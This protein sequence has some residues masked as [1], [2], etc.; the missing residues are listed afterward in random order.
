MTS[1]FS[2]YAS[3]VRMN[4]Q[5]DEPDLYEVD[6]NDI[7]DLLS[8][9]K[10]HCRNVITIERNSFFLVLD[11][12][13]ASKT[14]FQL[15][16]N[17]FIESIK[18]RIEIFLCV[19]DSESTEPPNSDNYEALFEIESPLLKEFDLRERFE[20]VDGYN[21]EKLKYFCEKDFFEG[22][23][24]VVILETLVED[25][26]ECIVNRRQPEVPSLCFPLKGEVQQ[27]RE[28]Q[29]LLPTDP[30]VGG[31]PLRVVQTA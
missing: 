22:T 14:L 29:S 11:S 3:I 10:F 7:Y 21:L 23:L 27:E 6:F 15:L 26:C 28:V 30:R 25:R 1:P 12:L 4:V 17:L 31:Q 13:Q 2:D 20:G 8:K 24:E 9:F 18:A 19:E 5:F 16:N